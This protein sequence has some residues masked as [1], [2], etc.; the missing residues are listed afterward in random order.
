MRRRDFISTLGGVAAWPLTARAQQPEPVRR[1]GVLISSTEDDPQVRRQTAAFR[2]GLLELG[3]SF[4]SVSVAG[5]STPMR[6][7][8]GLRE[9]MQ[10]RKFIGAGGKKIKQ[11][12]FAYPASECSHC[13]RGP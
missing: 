7:T 6:L 2:Q 10:R 8:L 5:V 4:G 12:F 11:K 1:V 9:D 3:S 13:G